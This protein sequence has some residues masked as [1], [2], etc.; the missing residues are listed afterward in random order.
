M[1]AGLLTNHRFCRSRI[2]EKH[3]FSE[4]RIN[5]KI[6]D[7]VE[8]GFMKNYKLSGSRIVEKNHNV[9]GN[10]IDVETACHNG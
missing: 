10:G 6:M 9:S 7:S 2:D 8:A 5:E 3:R 1:K 4:S